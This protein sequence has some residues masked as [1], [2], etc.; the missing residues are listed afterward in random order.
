MGGKS[1][2]YRRGLIDRIQER[3]AG[4]I[5]SYQLRTLRPAASCMSQKVRCALFSP[6]KRKS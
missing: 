1:G 4:L 5:N 6:A 3:Q 2:D